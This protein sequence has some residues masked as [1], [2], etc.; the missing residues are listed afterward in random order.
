MNIN[1]KGINITDA[2][3]KHVNNS[4]Q[5]IIDGFYGFIVEDISVTLELNPS[6]KTNN[7]IVNCKRQ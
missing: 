3:K 1:I 6:H 4:F 2:F 5:H 7:H